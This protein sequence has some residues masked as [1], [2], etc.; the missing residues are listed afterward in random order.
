MQEGC[1][2]ATLSS[3]LFVLIMEVLNSLLAWVEEHSFLTPLAGIL[4]A[5]VSLY[6]DDLV[7]LLT[8]KGRYQSLA[9]LRDYSP[10]WI[11]V[12]LLQSTS[13]MMT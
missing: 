13:P 3:M 8:I 9:L 11:Q 12:W 2:R 6:A 4:G 7:I 1:G 10:T 5:R